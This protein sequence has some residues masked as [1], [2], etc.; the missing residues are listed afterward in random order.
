MK[1]IIFLGSFF[2][3]MSASAE[4]EWIYIKN[5]NLAGFSREHPAEVFYDKRLVSD[6]TQFKQFWMMYSLKNRL[7][8][9][10]SSFKEKIEIDCRESTFRKVETIGYIFSNATGASDIVKNTD[11]SWRLLKDNRSSAYSIVAAKLCQIPPRL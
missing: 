2:L 4:T 1:L 9:G 3:L 5:E 7:I 6:Q 11:P 10:W 8:D